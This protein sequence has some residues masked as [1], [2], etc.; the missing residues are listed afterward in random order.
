MLDN[1]ICRL[2]FYI[3]ARRDGR[4]VCWVERDFALPKAAETLYFMQN[5]P[6]DETTF[7]VETFSSIYFHLNLSNLQFSQLM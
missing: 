2:R 7:L 3:K 1:V 4:S 6:R 5:F